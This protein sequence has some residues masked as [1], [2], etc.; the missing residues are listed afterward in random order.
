MIRYN[1]FFALVTPR[2]QR[3]R[4]YRKNKEKDT[5]RDWERETTK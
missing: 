4:K 5:K 2:D 1:N 3:Q